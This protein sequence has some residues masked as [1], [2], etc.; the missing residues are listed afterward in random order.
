MT[1]DA[2]QRLLPSEPITP[3][4]RQPEPDL[5]TFDCFESNSLVRRIEVRRRTRGF[6][7]HR[8]VVRWILIS[9]VA[10]F[11]GLIALLIWVVTRGIQ[12][13]KLSATHRLVRSGHV[14]AP[15]LV[16]CGTSCVLACMAAMLVAFV[17]PIAVSSGIPQIKCVLNGLKIPR[18]VRVKTL[19]VKAL[20]VAFSVAA[21]LPVGIEG[22]MIHCGAICGAGVSQGKSTMFGIDTSFTKFSGFRN[23]KEKRD[24]V[25]AGA[26]AG[27]ACAFGAPIGGVLFSLEEGSSFWNQKLTWRTFF[28]SMM[29]YFVLAMFTSALVDDNTWG[30]L[31]DSSMFTFGDFTAMG[32]N[33]F[34]YSAYELPLFILMGVFGGLAGA[35]YNHLNMLI[36][37]W[38]R[39]SV[40]NPG[41]K[42]FEAGTTGLLFALCTFSIS[43]AYRD[44]C[45]SIDESH[46]S[47]TQHIVR[48]YCDEGYFNPL[49]SILLVPFDQAIKLLF[50]SSFNF[51]Y[52][53][54]LIVFT[55]IFVASCWCYGL[56]IPSGL[57][58][59]TLFAGAAFGRAIGQ[60]VNDNAAFATVDAG[61]YSLIGAAAVL[62]GMAR[63]TISLT[64][65]LIEATGD[66]QYGLPIMMTLMTARWMGGCFNE[67]LYDIHIH[68]NGW[69]FLEFDPPPVVQYLLAFDIM[70]IEPIYLREVETVARVVEV[71]TNCQHNGFPVVERSEPSSG[72]VMPAFC[73]M[74]KRHHLT[75]L[76]QAHCFSEE[77]PEPYKSP[78]RMQ[79]AAMET[80]YPRYPTIADICLTPADLESFIDLTPYMDPA[81]YVMQQLAPAS[82]VFRL[83][84]TMGLR[85]I[86]VVTKANRLVGIITRKDLTHIR[87]RRQLTELVNDQGAMADHVGLYEDVSQYEFVKNFLERHRAP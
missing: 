15:I 56:S 41:R 70:S 8:A 86:P 19:F 18:V 59:P 74:I 65:I 20:G 27:V 5:D 61:T 13:Q 51:N 36:T 48:F 25:S 84:R 35:L 53:D 71:L 46:D 3:T 49:A 42:I 50:H 12:H 67:G 81:P 80:S 77:M 76:L 63:M 34:T 69:Q 79:Y 23:D 24:F 28:C 64:V 32:Q 62:G 22:P 38:R 78:P 16:H 82:T 4:H 33:E 83:Y 1:N 21:G 57:F 55:L 11:T 54:L 9:V 58:I 30:R 45:I 31:N 44:R 39:V 60:I 37:K 47:V 52:T 17:E 40:Q 73:G 43:L 66:I 68:M 75:V 7:R 72:A 26:A 87:F 2:Q 14:L 6:F 29:S 85:H 10:T